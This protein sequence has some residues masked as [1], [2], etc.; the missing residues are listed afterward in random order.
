MYLLRVSW[1]MIHLT[2]YLMNTM[3][4]YSHYK[5]YANQN[6]FPQSILLGENSAKISISTN[7][8]SIRLGKI[9]KKVKES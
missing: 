7:Q 4:P 1:A 2:F 9:W 5:M 8:C 6:A 3:N